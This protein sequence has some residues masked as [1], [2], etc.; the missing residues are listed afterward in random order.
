MKS[1]IKVVLGLV[2]MLSI[3]LTMS[4]SFAD[5]TDT[6]IDFTITEK[7]ELTGG[8]N[9]TK[10]SSKPLKVIHN[11]S[12]GFIS[13]DNVSVKTDSGW[14]L[15]EKTTDFATVA[16]NSK[17]FSLV[18]DD[19][20]DLTIPYSSFGE[21]A[22]G[23]TES[24]EISGSTGIVTSNISE[25]IAELIVTLSFIP[26]HTITFDSYGGSE[27]SSL[28]IKDGEQIG[29][30][31]TTERDGYTFA[32]W[33][34]DAESGEQI[35][36]NT[37]PSANTTYYAR[38]KANKYTVKYNGNG[39]TSGSTASSSHTYDVEKALTKNGFV[40]EGYVFEGW[41]EDPNGE[42]AFY[43]NETE[44]LNL[45]NKA[46]GEVTLYAQW[47]EFEDFAV[48]SED[49]NSLRF[50][51]RSLSEIPDE[52]D[53]FNGLSSTSIYVN[54]ETI[55]SNIPWSSHSADI[56]KVIVE[57]E[58][59]PNIMNFWFEGF[60]NCSYLD[61]SKINTDYLKGLH[62]TFR[63]TGYN[64]DTFK[65]VG[66][67]DWDTSEVTTMSHTFRDSGHSA[68]SW[69]IGNLSKW[70]TG[71]VRNMSY[72]FSSSGYN[73]ISW[74]VGNLS[75]WNTGSVTD[76]SYMFSNAGY[77]A[78]TWNVGSLDD[79]D[80][81]N[82]TTM[83]FMFANA[84][85]STASWSIG[86]LSNWNISK[87]NT[88][89]NVFNGAGYSS[90][91]WTLGD[92][93]KWDINGVS[94][95]TSLFRNTGYNATSW[96]IGDISTWDVSTV[97][98]MNYLFNNA[99]YNARTWNVGNISEWDV[100]NVT[101]MNY[102]FNS[103]GVKELNLSGWNNSNVTSMSYM[104]TGCDKL[105]KVTIGTDFAFIGNACYL[106]N[107]K[108]KIEGS[109]G[110]WYN[111][112]TGEE[113][114]PASVPSN[115]A[116]TYVVVMPK[117][118]TIEGF[119]TVKG[120]DLEDVELEYNEDSNIITAV[121]P[122]TEESEEETPNPPEEAVPEI[123]E[124]NYGT[125]EP[126][127]EYTPGE[128]VDVDYEESVVKTK[129]PVSRTKINFT[130]WQVDEKGNIIAPMTA[131]INAFDEKYSTYVV[132]N[133]NTGKTKTLEGLTADVTVIYAI[134]NNSS[135]TL[136]NAIYMAAYFNM[137]D[138]S[139]DWHI[140]TWN[141]SN[142]VEEDCDAEIA[143]INT[144]TYV[145]KEI[146]TKKVQIKAPT[147]T[148]AYSFVPA[149][150]LVAE[151][152]MTWNEWLDSKYNTFK[153]VELDIKTLNFE[154]VSYD[155]EI[156]ATQTYGFVISKKAGLYNAE[157]TLII[158]WD[159][160]VND[161][162]L[163]VEQGEAR[164]IFAEIEENVS[165]VIDDSITS[166]APYA[167]YE[168]L[169]LTAVNIP[170]SV[171]TIGDRAFG[172]C[173]NL[174]IVILNEG[175]EEIGGD[176]FLA[177]MLE[178]ITIPSTVKSIG[179]YAFTEAYNITEI[180]VSE[181]NLYFTSVDGVLYNKEKTNLICCPYRKTGTLIVPEGVTTIER[182]AFMYTGIEEVVL[183]DS[184][185]TIEEYA[186]TE[187]SLRS[188][189]IPGG[190][191]TI[192]TNT[193]SAT[194][195][196][197]VTIEEGVKEIEEGAFFYSASLKE[198][199]LPQ[200]LISIGRHCFTN[201]GIETLT[202]GENIEYIE[203]GAFEGCPFLETVYMKMNTPPI[204]G[205][206]IFTKEDFSLMPDDFE[207]IPVITFYFKNK[208]VANALIPGTHYSE[209]YGIKSTDYNW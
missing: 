89:S 56:V 110:N 21:V 99:G 77:N 191:E 177:T 172:T 47:S 62:N 30:L 120:E 11:G 105:K 68:T 136:E 111:I 16:S 70:K 179:F 7:I 150:V 67:S 202:L 4:F 138:Y 188:I 18:I 151:K 108:N 23:K 93:S 64:V 33:F 106:P 194:P 73:A 207:E 102:L 51:K 127:T 63:S 208:E 103:S 145:A 115:I 117:D 15:V 181:E 55:R 209:E 19:T 13:I 130:Y 175:L 104:F 139:N 148:T 162:G 142:Y 192:K 152:G 28:V 2:L 86:D 197:T 53:E 141:G 147:S 203:D 134:R 101:T 74:D 46:N 41:N 128:Y 129:N 195:L 114:A 160:L 161:Y 182:D 54:V 193:F 37:I 14:R 164:D 92:L 158:P 90:K 166:I 8:S 173:E 178:T 133:T 76:A 201:S 49:D 65:I 52:G 167:F 143:S 200:S 116:A 196:E 84:G 165:L 156:D 58:I 34:T 32:G 100:S 186:F 146:K 157:G 66:L 10:L 85:Y 75:D 204:L 22:A 131:E 206:N 6:T 169:N 205:M 187:S 79:W 36:E 91:V 184:M 118:V 190:V 107:Q 176:A 112:E 57:D 9:E 12:N 109:D 61:V 42:G 140:A 43:H 59:R 122:P 38:W 163:D 155:Q 135:D 60:V 123:I 83:Q 199:T 149:G 124:V 153:E 171:K 198:L 1:I 72:M 78:R 87:T 180:N 185:T 170:G 39:S 174:E 29:N 48:Y 17:L 20:H 24:K 69:D 159:S 183:P 3:G 137:I 144:F 44:I 168:C 27:V 126:K 81:S 25:K 45:T 5:S 113:Y 94:S 35:T 189:N 97:T 96:Y 50:Y 80:L 88:L 31:P 82:L 40:K 71:R 121:T 95:V 98:N 132:Y 26:E 119:G 154:D 125:F